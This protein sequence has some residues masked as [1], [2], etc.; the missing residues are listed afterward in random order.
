MKSKKQKREEAKLRNE[1]WA[2]LTPTQK[3]GKLKQRG[4]T[5]TRQYREI[6]NE[7]ETAVSG[8]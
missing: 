5:H 6:K 8:S 3:L 2:K 4:L 1:A 7:A